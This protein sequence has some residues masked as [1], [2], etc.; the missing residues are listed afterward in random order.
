M[1]VN[2]FKG[3]PASNSENNN[4]LSVVYASYKD[5]ILNNVLSHEKYKTFIY[6]KG[7]NENKKKIINNN[8]LTINDLAYQDKN[9]IIHLANIGFEAHTFLYHIITQYNNLTEFVAF[10]PSG[11]HGRKRNDEL[12]L[13]ICPRKPAKN[14]HMYQSLTDATAGVITGPEKWIAKCKLAYHD[15]FSMRWNINKEFNIFT[16]ECSNILDTRV[17]LNAKFIVSKRTIK[18]RPLSFYLNAIKYVDERSY[19]IGSYDSSKED[20]I[21]FWGVRNDKS[22]N[23]VGAMH[24]SFKTHKNENNLDWCGACFLEYIWT[25]IFS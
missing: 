12:I 11:Y 25:Y 18:K 1:K 20:K 21:P 7:N 19:R 23:V 10:I 8:N 22:D 5:T 15:V 24:K 14:M 6:E 2:N 16:N 3:I 9:N 4:H 13:K 17:D